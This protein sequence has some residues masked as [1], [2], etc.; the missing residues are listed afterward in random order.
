HRCTVTDADLEYEGSVTISEDLM[1]AARILEHEQ[2]QIWN[3]TNGSRITTYAMAGRPGSGVICI[4]GAA[5]HL[6]RPGDV[7]IIAAFAILEQS[8]ARDW[9]P[10]V[11]MVD[12]ANRIKGALSRESAGPR[13]V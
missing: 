10:S 11:V 7:V 3:V 6:M 9:K 12:G 4:N 2:V 1:E 8:E 5:A 13:R